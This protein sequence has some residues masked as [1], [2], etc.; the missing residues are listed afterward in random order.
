MLVVGLL[1]LVLAFAAPT[2][3]RYAG[4]ATGWILAAFPA[5]VF[6]WLCVLTP[7]IG[8]GEPWR[9]S[10][11]WVPGLGIA[12]S[13]HIDGLGLLFGMLISG[14][15]A[16]VLVYAQGYLGEHKDL[17]RFYTTLLLFMIS[18]LGVVWADNIVSL[19]VFWELT[20]VTSYLLI[21]FDHH[22]D[23]ARKSALQ[24]LLVTG[25]GGLALLA[26]LIL[27][28][29]AT[30]SMELSE[31]AARSDLLLE[32]PL[33]TP[34]LLLV[35]LGAMTKSA[36]FPFH[37]WLPGA[38]EAPT[39][40]S[41]YLH[42]S[43]MVKAGVYL[44]ARM[45]PTLGDADLWTPLVGTV[46]AVTMVVGAWLAMRQVYLKL[47]L[48][49]STVSA[50]GGM[51][52]LIGFGGELGAKAAATFILAHALYKGALFLVAGSIDHAAHEKDV[53]KL[54]GL[55]R[56]MP[57]TAVG[58]MVA[59]LSMSGFMPLFGFIS[60]ELLLEAALETPAWAGLFGAASVIG[61]VGMVV[62]AI[63]VGVRPFMGSWKETPRKP[64]EGGPTLWL[65]PTILAA[66]SL[67][68]GVAPSLV[69]KVLLSPAAS[70]IYG[71][72]ME[73]KLSLWHGLTPALGLSVLAI[74]VGVGVFLMRPGFIRLTSLS[75]RVGAYGPARWYTWV[76]DGMNEIARVQTRV[77]QSGYLRAYLF[78]M[79]VTTVGLT[80]WMMLSSGALAAPTELTPVQLHEAGLL[81]LVLLGALLAVRSK[82]SL[83]AVAALGVVGYGVALIYVLFGAPDLAM[84]QFAIET[85]T[86]VLFVFVFYHLP[87]FRILTSVLARTRDALV[88]ISAGMLMA[89]L[90]IMA[91][92]QRPLHEP[93]S[94]Y[95]AEHSVSKGYGRNVVNVIL[96]DFRSIDTLGEIV[97]LAVA[98]VGVYALLRLREPR[99]GGSS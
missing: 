22:R 19:F 95:F 60:K 51:V 86:V 35:L 75:D 26:G 32:H 8:A 40:V 1:A 21:G 79:I 48:A 33:L 30:G 50:L 46:G 53:R 56:L 81:A 6:V 27:M 98:G 58:A 24:A 59:G 12:L 89:A 42:S 80:G 14:I 69:Q 97:V 37:F 70:A 20:S 67:L 63:A 73:V 99:E 68:F 18:M 90:V 93:I 72:P 65:G 13:F 52:M 92:S 44:L 11:E 34:A 15:G 36:Q 45:Q 74:A 28:A 41:A 84:T 10:Q 5:G 54:S 91:V 64:H 66:L 57:L 62:V 23:T 38:M 55:G 47:L 7:D 88:A 3:R 83:G 9:F 17:G 85:L 71:V 76:F 2:I 29:I 94:A 25:I 43:T 82:S 96:V 39:P 61:A 49:Y 87:K 77:L 78:I 16:L 31:I 4:S